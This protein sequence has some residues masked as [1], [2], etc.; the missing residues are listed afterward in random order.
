LHHC[1]GHT[2]ANTPTSDALN[3]ARCAANQKLRDAPVTMTRRIE[4][5][6]IS[7]RQRPLGKLPARDER[8]R[9]IP[10][11]RAPSVRDTWAQWTVKQ[12]RPRT[13]SVP[14]G[15]DASGERLQWRNW[16]VS[17]GIETRMCPA[18]ND[19]NKT[20]VSV[21]RTKPPPTRA[22]ELSECLATYR[23]RL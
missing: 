2:R 11:R 22:T 15:N 1:P 13:E 8:R 20:T 14:F 12:D 19:R 3:A 21:K 23:W 6:V 17:G 16:S 5:S 9:W 4:S 10:R 18:G 7:N